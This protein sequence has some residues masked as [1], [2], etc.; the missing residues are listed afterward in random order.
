MPLTHML[1]KLTKCY[2]LLQATNVAP[3]SFPCFSP[4]P[5]CHFNHFACPWSGVEISAQKRHFSELLFLFLFI[6]FAHFLFA[7][8]LYCSCTIPSLY[9]ERFMHYFYL[10][11][12]MRTSVL[13]SITKHMLLLWHELVTLRAVHHS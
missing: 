10:V 9:L 13:S 11:P 2:F 6:L 7:S 1:C 4:L 3:D 12:A 8:Y 5:K